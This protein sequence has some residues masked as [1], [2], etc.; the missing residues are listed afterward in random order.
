MNKKK[1][2]AVTYVDLRKAFDTVTHSILLKKLEKMGISENLLVWFKNYLENRSQC[3]F[4]NNLTSDVLPLTCGVPQGS[5]LG[6]TLFLIYI[7][8]VKNVLLNAKRLLYAD[9]TAL[10]L[11]EEN[12]DTLETNLQYDLV[13]FT[14][15]CNQNRLTVNTKKNK[16]VIYGTTKLLKKSRN[17]NL[18]IN[19]TALHRES[20][21]N[22]L[23]IY[24]DASLNFN[25]HIDYVNKVT[26]H[27]IFMLSKI[28]AYMDQRTA[29]YIYKSMIMPI[30]DYGDIIFEG[31]NKNRLDK[32]KCT[33]N[34]GLKICMNIRNKIG[35]VDLHRLA[36][37]AQLY[38]R[39]CSNLKK[40]MYLQQENI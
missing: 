1:F 26:S 33:Q 10:Y 34:R 9:D 27:K 22:Y 28:R 19:N 38:V 18:R 8:D 29:I 3:T 39:R 7:N 24:L 30:F 2:T 16:Y 20:L 13:H 25:K 35:T 4:V 31:G 5:V 12:L 23:G 40:Y 6:P 21:Y 37:V 36:G 14:N 17:L 11:S 32:L 15:W